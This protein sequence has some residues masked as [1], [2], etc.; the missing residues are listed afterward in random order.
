MKRLLLL[1][2]LVA[3]CSSPEAGRKTGQPGADPG[4]RDAIVEIHQGA[5]PYH[6]TPCRMTDLECP[7]TT[8]SFGTN[9][10]NAN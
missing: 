4:N 7:E 10:D 9:R 1:A 2:A 5:E 3:A 6:D 8:S